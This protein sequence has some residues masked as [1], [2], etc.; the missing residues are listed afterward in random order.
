MMPLLETVTTVTLLGICFWDAAEDKQVSD[1]LRV[2]AWPATAPGLVVRAFRTASGYYAFQGLPGLEDLENPAAAERDT[3]GSP[4]EARPF[5]VEVRD[6]LNRFL[7]LRF[8]VALPLP[9]SGLYRPGAPASPLADSPPADDLVRFYLFSTPSRDPAPGSVAVRAC[10]VEWNSGRPAAFARLEIEVH[11]R[12]RNDNRRWY[13]LADERGCVAVLFPYPT[14]VTRLGA[15]PPGLPLSQ[16]VWPLTVRV[17]YRPSL[18][19]GLAVGE[20]P[21]L[22]QLTDDDS[23]PEATLW[24]TESGPDTAALNRDLKFASELVLRTGRQP[25]LWVSPGAP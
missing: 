24:P 6:P 17:R 16:Q 22:D 10:L 15:S 20:P 25:T 5:I 11:G 13:G 23:L 4:P 9:Y 8:D 12:R 19:A 18:A 14:F 1:G 7:P 3:I 2:T 21:R